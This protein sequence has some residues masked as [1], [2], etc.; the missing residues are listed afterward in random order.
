ME[1]F[2]TQSGVELTIKPVSVGAIQ[3]FLG[4]S[5]FLLDMFS[6]TASG[7][8]DVEAVFQEL[9][10][11]EQTK[12]LSDFEPLYNY[13]MGWGVETDPPEEAQVDLALL[14]IHPQTK[15]EARIKWLRILVLEQVDMGE[16]VGRILALSMPQTEEQEGE[17]DTE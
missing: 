16:L 1:T 7:D 14:R 3:S 15:R 9:T 12:A 17:E 10:P 8:E 13:C 2:V 6:R 5:P 4:D 11:A